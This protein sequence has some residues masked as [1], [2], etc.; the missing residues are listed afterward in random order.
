MACPEL[1]PSHPASLPPAP[2]T[3]HSGLPVSSGQSR[4]LTSA[5]WPMSPSATPHHTTHRA[6]RLRLGH[7]PLPAFQPLSQVPRPPCQLGAALDAP[8]SASLLRLSLAAALG[9]LGLSRQRPLRPHSL[10][11]ALPIAGP[12]KGPRPPW[13][14]CLSPDLVRAAG[15][16]RLAAVQGPVPSQPCGLRGA[17][18]LPE[19]L[20]S[21]D[22]HC[23]PIVLTAD[24]GVSR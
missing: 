4:R 10:W 14:P 11:P 9:L 3:L 12:H 24:A 23:R 6:S 2:L 21:P 17:A 18:L 5:S 15:D 19:A 13:S 8:P 16:S 1:A 7:W 22:A 20:T